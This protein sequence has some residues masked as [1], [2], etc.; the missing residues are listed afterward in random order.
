MKVLEETL[1]SYSRSYNACYLLCAT[2]CYE[3][4]VND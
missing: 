3:V 2:Y 4:D 1:H